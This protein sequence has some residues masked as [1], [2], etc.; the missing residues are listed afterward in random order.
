MLTIIKYLAAWHTKYIDAAPV[1]LLCTVVDPRE[2]NGVAIV[3]Q[4]KLHFK[5]YSLH[6]LAV[7]GQPLKTHF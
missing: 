5:A 1:E 2:L 3:L 7:S 4:E 6:P